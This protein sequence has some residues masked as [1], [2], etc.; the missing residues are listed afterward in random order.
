MVGG[1]DDTILLTRKPGA[2]K[3]QREQ[4]LDPDDPALWWHI[5]GGAPHCPLVVGFAMM[6]HWCAVYC[7]VTEE[8]S[9]RA[10]EE[11]GARMEY[12]GFHSLDFPVESASQREELVNFWES[13]RVGSRILMWHVF[14]AHTEPEPPRLRI[15]P[16]QVAARW[17]ERWVT[18]PPRTCGLAVSLARAHAHAP[19]PLLIVWCGVK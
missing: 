7:Y 12:D 17:A 13:T 4:D 16:Y 1:S 10:R 18:A 15:S 5:P 8:D 11:Y 14:P 19:L 3:R 6:A 9:K 2:K